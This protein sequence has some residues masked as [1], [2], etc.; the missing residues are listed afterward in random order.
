MRNKMKI[1]VLMV[2]VCVF[3]FGM[4]V[5]AD[6]NPY[7]ITVNST[8]TDEDN[9]SKRTIRSIGEYSGF[10][11]TPEYFDTNNAAFFAKSIQLFGT[12]E[13]NTIYVENGIGETRYGIY[14]TNAPY[15]EYY[16]MKA[17]YGYSPTGSVNSTGEYKP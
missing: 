6:S 14:I 10:S 17:E 15:N 8:K 16:F 4:N 1:A 12:A 7:R 5:F 9:M 13:S 11:V 2:C 3:M